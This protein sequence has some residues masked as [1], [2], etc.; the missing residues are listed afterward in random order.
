[1][2]VRGQVLSCTV[3]GLTDRTHAQDHNWN[4]RA[5]DCVLGYVSTSLFFLWLS[6][7]G[8]EIADRNHRLYIKDG[9]TGF[10]PETQTVGNDSVQLNVAQG[11]WTATNF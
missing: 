8:C 4:L 11:K 5:V 6:L 9:C 2:A 7:E 1:M 10:L 3:I